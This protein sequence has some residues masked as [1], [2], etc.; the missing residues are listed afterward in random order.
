M[1]PDGSSEVTVLSSASRVEL[2][3]EASL[4]EAG[5]PGD[6]STAEGVGASELASST[7]S[8]RPKPTRAAFFFFFTY[9]HIDVSENGVV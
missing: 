9:K 7:S 3:T 4:Y 1:A 5:G 8:S 6:D 2:E